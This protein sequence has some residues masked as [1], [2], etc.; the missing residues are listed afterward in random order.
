MFINQ[1]QHSFTGLGKYFL[2]YVVPLKPSSPP[3]PRRLLVE[4][5]SKKS[6]R[7]QGTPGRMHIYPVVDTGSGD[8]KCGTSATTA[9][10]A[11]R[12]F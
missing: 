2:Y 6:F 1:Y 9:E 12:A 8:A 10:C 4:A 5:S 7:S 3:S 11:R